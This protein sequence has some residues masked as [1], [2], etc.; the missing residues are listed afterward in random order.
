[1]SFINADN[2]SYFLIKDMVGNAIQFFLF[3]A[4]ICCW[5]PSF[6]LC[7]VCRLYPIQMLQ[8]KH[9]YYSKLCQRMI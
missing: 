6:G 8:T 1:M 7:C 5:V 2:L 9:R 3:S 4:N